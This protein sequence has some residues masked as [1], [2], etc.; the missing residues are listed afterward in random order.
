MWGEMGKIGVVKKN[1]QSFCY[2]SLFL[3]CKLWLPFR[4]HFFGTQDLQAVAQPVAVAFCILCEVATS[5]KPPRT[6]Y[7]NNNQLV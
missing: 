5:L 4:E 1:L 7:E 3:L 6:S 2:I